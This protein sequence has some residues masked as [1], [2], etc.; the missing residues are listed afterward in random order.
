MAYGLITI[1][2][3]LEGGECEGWHCRQPEKNPP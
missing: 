1:D 2:L 3:K